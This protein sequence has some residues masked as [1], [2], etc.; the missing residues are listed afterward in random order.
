MET[1]IWRELDEVFLDEAPNFVS[2]NGTILDDIS[3]LGFSHAAGGDRFTI[4]VIA[5]KRV[6]E[7]MSARRGHEGQNGKQCEYKPHGASYFDP[8]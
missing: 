4:A 5:A 8:K 1:P 7:I 2:M 3:R 6:I